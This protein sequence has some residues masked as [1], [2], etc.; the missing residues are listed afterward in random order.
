MAPH[1]GHPEM[2]IGPL[3]LNSSRPRR[4]RAKSPAVWTCSLRSTRGLPG[5]FLKKNGPP[6][7]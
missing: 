7:C 6:L 2:L 4:R 5:I 3:G 1:D